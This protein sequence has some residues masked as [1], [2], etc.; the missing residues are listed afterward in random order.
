MYR[1]DIYLE[2]DTWYLG[3]R[4]RKSGYY[5]CCAM[6]GGRD[7][8]DL[9]IR[10]VEGTYNHCL[11]IV[12]NEAL[13][14]MKKPSEIHIHSANTYI[15]DMIKNSLPGWEKNCF[16]NSRGED[17]K[18]Q[19]AW[20][21]LS[22]NIRGHMIVPEYGLHEYSHWMKWMMMRDGNEPVDNIVEKPEKPHKQ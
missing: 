19:A 9:Q 14:R 16:R 7:Y 5:I 13:G 22:M 3:N 4:K 1:V 2:S 6:P 10:S 21:I 11:L 17:I 18:D 20:M 15:L 8:D 12:L